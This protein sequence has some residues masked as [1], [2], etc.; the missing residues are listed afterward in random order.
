MKTTHIED[1]NLGVYLA[2]S[3]GNYIIN[4]DEEFLLI[5]GM[6]NDKRKVVELIKVA[7]SFGLP[8]ITVE[9]RPDQRP[10]SHEE[11]DEQMERLKNG[12]T[13]DPYDLGHLIDQYNEA[14]GK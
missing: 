12:I 5:Y 4:E 7:K 13:P 3:E 8:D 1:T 6:R 2:K 10:V 11:Y 9:F 14:N